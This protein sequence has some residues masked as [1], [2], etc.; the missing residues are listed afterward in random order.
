MKKIITIFFLLLV[1]FLIASFIYLKTSAQDLGSNF[2]N[3][4]WRY[5]FARHPM[6]RKILGLHFDGDAKYDY[7]GPRYSNITIKIIPM[8][9]LS[10]NNRAAESFSQK[11]QATTGKPTKYLVY[12]DIAFSL[13]SYRE[14]LEKQLPED[15]T[16]LPSQGAIIYLIVASQKKDDSNLLASTLK[17]NGIVLFESTLEND[18]RSD[19]SQKFDEYLAGLLLHEFGHQIGLNHNAFLECLMNEKT[20]FSDSGSLIDMKDDFCEFEKEEIKKMKF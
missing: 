9:G 16:V 12:P 17:E 10:I 11:V 18:M 13:T 20:E 6:A 7:L 8:K 4:N 3:D 15:S 1:I 2:F 14:D 19:T 5:E